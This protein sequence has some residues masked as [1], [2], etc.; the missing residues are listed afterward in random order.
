MIDIEQ[1]STEQ[2]Q[3]ARKHSSTFKGFPLYNSCPHAFIDLSVPAEES[4][5]DSDMMHT[6]S[7]KLPNG[8]FVTF[9]VISHE[10]IDAG[11]GTIDMKY[12]GHGETKVIAFTPN[13]QPDQIATTDLMYTFVYAEK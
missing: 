7:V 8:Q 13:G 5:A 2:V 1:L 3:D 11:T 4:T 10:R 12:H 9:T 6:L